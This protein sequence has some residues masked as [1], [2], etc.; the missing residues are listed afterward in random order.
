MRLTGFQKI[1]LF[2]LALAAWFALI[3]QFYI[4]MH[5]G[6]AGTTELLI[7]YFSYFTIDTNIIVALC[8]TLLL[9]SPHSKAGRFF[10]KYKT[11][12]A[13]TVYI[14]IVGIIYNLILRFLWNPQ[15]LQWIVDELLHTVIPV[16]FFIYWL[17]FTTKQNLQ[18]LAF[19]P[20]L[21]Y[22]LLYIIFLIIR[23]SLSGFY[24]Y[25][26]IDAY[27][28]GLPRMLFNSGG[29]ALAIAGMSLFFIAIGNYVYHSRKINL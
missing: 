21:I 11:F 16:L 18:W 27:K 17:A 13:I 15:G 24:P 5:S 3:A 22:P 29:I 28:I 1:Y 12:T 10:G 6:I 7:R 14:L 23:G 2:I 4:N 9:V 8:C 20:W 19:L 26:F 25:P